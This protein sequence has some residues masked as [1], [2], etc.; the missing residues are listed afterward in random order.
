MPKPELIPLKTLKKQKN[1]NCV[2][3]SLPVDLVQNL[4]DLDEEVDD[5]QVQLDGGDDV[6]LGGD[7]GHDHVCVEDDEA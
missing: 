2:A 1:N 7:A 4:E 3:S 5:V 6:V